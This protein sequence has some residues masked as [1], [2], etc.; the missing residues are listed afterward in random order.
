[1]LFYRFFWKKKLGDPLTENSEENFRGN[2][3]EMLEDVP[4]NLRKK[5]TK[6]FRKTIFLEESFK[7]KVRNY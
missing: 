2:S 4:K 3:E 5:S 7:K 1:M 6:D